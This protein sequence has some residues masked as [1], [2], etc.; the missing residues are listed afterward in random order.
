MKPQSDPDVKQRGTRIAAIIPTYQRAWSIARAVESALAQ[1]PQPE[2]IVVDDGST[3]DTHAVLAGFGD[4]ITV[5]HQENQG[6]SHSRNAGAAATNADWIAFLDSDDHW[7]DHHLSRM[8]D[9]IASNEGSS[10]V[11]FADTRRTVSEGSASLF[12]L[13]EFHPNGE[14]DVTADATR[15]VLLPRQPLMVQSAVIARDAFEAVGGFWESLTHR[16]DT[17]LWFLLGIGRPMCAVN[18]IGCVMT[19]EDTSGL[20][21]TERFGGQ[22]TVY[23]TD[24]IAIYSD[25]L[26]RFDKVLT[27]S[28]KKEIVRRVSHARLNLARI[29]LRTHPLVA[30]RQ[31]ATALFRSPGL[32]SRRMASRLTNSGDA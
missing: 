28:D 27:D 15:W 2:V 10:D 8:L 29:S 22:T 14:F 7:T 23:W 24:T 11:Y 25:A 30:G 26:D 4:R 12:D 3:D 6:L 21:Q 32:V 19:D 31:V 13:A 1:A 16:E 17:H 5:I 20:R 9:A 18:G